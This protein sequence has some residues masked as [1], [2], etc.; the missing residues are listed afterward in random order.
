MGLWTWG[1]FRPKTNY[2]GINFAGKFYGDVLRELIEIQRKVGAVLPAGRLVQD[3]LYEDFEQIAVSHLLSPSEKK[4]LQASVKFAAYYYKGVN[5]ADLESWQELKK[6][7]QEYKK[8]IIEGAYAGRRVSRLVTRLSDEEIIRSQLPF[9]MITPRV[10][11]AREFMETNFQSMV[12]KKPVD[13]VFAHLQGVSTHVQSYNETATHL[14]EKFGRIGTL[15]KK[16]SIL[17]YLLR[18]NKD[19]RINMIESL[20]VSAEPQEESAY[21]ELGKIL[22][23]LEESDDVALAF[24]R[25]ADGRPALVVG[26]AEKALSDFLNEILPNNLSTV[27]SAAEDVYNVH[28]AAAREYG[29]FDYYRQAKAMFRQYGALNFAAEQSNVSEDFKRKFS[30]YQKSARLKTNGMLQFGVVWNSETEFRSVKRYENK[31]DF[32]TLDATKDNYVSDFDEYEYVF[33][34]FQNFMRLAKNSQD[35]LA[36]TLKEN[37]LLILNEEESGVRIVAPKDSKRGEILLARNMRDVAKAFIR[38]HKENYLTI[39]ALKDPK[40]AGFLTQTQEVMSYIEESARS[41]AL[42]PFYD[43]RTDNLIPNNKNGG[44]NNNAWMNLGRSWNM[45]AA[46]RSYPKQGLYRLTYAALV[47]RHPENVIV[48]PAFRIWTSSENGFPG[49]EKYAIGQHTFTQD[50]QRAYR[51][52]TTF[53]G[54]GGVLQPAGNAF[55]TTPGEDSAN[56][57]IA[58]SQYPH[59]VSTQAEWLTWEWGRPALHMESIYGTENRYVSNVTRFVEDIGLQEVNNNPAVGYDVKLTNNYMFN[60]Y[61]LATVST[62]L[63]IALPVLQGVSGFAFLAPFVFF[64]PLAFLFMQSINYMNFL[65]HWRQ[66]GSLIFGMIKG[67]KDVVSAFA[68]YVSMIPSFTKSRL[69]AANEAFKFTPTL[70]DMKFMTEGQKVRSDISHLLWN[71]QH[72]ERMQNAVT[73][74]GGLLVAVSFLVSFSWTSFLGILALFA[75]G[76]AAA[77]LI[78]KEVRDSVVDRNDPAYFKPMS[79]GLQ[80][81]LASGWLVVA[82]LISGFLFTTTLAGAVLLGLGTILLAISRM[83]KYSQVREEGVPVAPV[84]IPFDSLIG[85][86]GIL[87]WAGGFFLTTTAGP[88]V[89]IL[90]AL[91]SV[92]ALTGSYVYK[93]FYE[94][95]DVRNDEGKI[96]K[97]ERIHGENL[98]AMFTTQPKRLALFFFVLAAFPLW[99]MTASFFSVPYLILTGVNW[100]FFITISFLATWGGAF[101]NIWDSRRYLFDS[102]VKNLYKNIEKERAEKARQQKANAS[103]Q[104]V[105]QAP[106]QPAD[107]SQIQEDIDVFVEQSLIRQERAAEALSVMEGHLSRALLAMPAPVENALPDRSQTPDD[108]GGISFNENNLVIN[109][110]VDGEGMPLPADMQTPEVVSIAGLTPVIRDIS[111]VTSRNVPVL[112]ELMRG[113]AL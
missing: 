102:L 106:P 13:D 61:M 94:T 87:S 33:V 5:S 29:D 44:I 24:L 6:A 32:E 74:S 69:L 17:G 104:P 16:T 10:L 4:A 38:F 18:I 103:V 19:M 68:Y 75:A 11:K 47:G 105:L 8:A 27:Q 111:P 26:K 31:E 14:L 66:E 30:F 79:V 78:A 9:M 36:T 57:I 45:D 41:E 23:H 77:W 2:F 49:V 112:M 80:L 25:W 59:L 82:A 54:K 70:K 22:N 7:A 20:L 99:G 88:V 62:L 84:P 90:Y 21:K 51:G 96:E 37:L 100:A 3:K 43:F 81:T 67:F 35:P 97:K 56:Y 64:V 108:V 58:L 15:S 110:K 42:I 92:S 107:A 39:L 113:A 109:L 50:L 101:S 60:H 52:L 83:I 53:Y 55:F 91:A 85:W 71:A 48:N 72:S 76:G 73:I 40:I 65:R 95:V 98:L 12:F 34:G 28:L 89:T 1:L 63:L 93:E 46:V 86:L